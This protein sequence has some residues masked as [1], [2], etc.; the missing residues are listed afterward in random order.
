MSL[1]TAKRVLR[2]EAEAIAGLADR[3]DHTFEK[4][5]DLLFHCQGRVAVTGM[6]K[7]GLIGRKIAATF[8]STGTP[9]YFLHASEALHG[10]LGVLA[11]EDR[12]ST[13]LNSSHMSISYAVFCLKKKKKK[14]K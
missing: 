14:K 11:A 6:G 3:L 2:I 1:E 4:A 5:V 12:K 10:D 7:S 9:A 13:R 8:C